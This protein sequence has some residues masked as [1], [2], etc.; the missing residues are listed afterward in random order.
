MAGGQKGLS[1]VGEPMVFAS[2]A[3]AI[4]MVLL[5]VAACSKLGDPTPIDD[6]NRTCEEAWVVEFDG[7]D[8][9]VNET[10]ILEQPWCQQHLAAREQEETA[11]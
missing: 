7:D 3:T 6:A 11:P 5:Y 4:I 10:A 2:V 8:E 1:F 9:T